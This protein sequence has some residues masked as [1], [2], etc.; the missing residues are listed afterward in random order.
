VRIS[1]IFAFYFPFFCLQGAPLDTA[2]KEIVEAGA[3]L[4]GRGLCPACSGN[5]SRRLDSERIVI[6]VSGKHKG[7]LT[8][9]DTLL[10][11]MQGIS[12]DREK[13]PSAETL[14]HIAIYEGLE[15]VG[16]IM[17]THSL[18]GVVLAQ[19]LKPENFLI[20]EGYELHKVFPGIATHESRLIIPIFENSQDII[21]MSKEVLSY[22]KDHPDTYG[23]LIR[24]HG[25]YTWGKDMN[26]TKTRIEAFE[27]IFEAE[28]KIRT[29]R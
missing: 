18:N 17:H 11:N 4:N 23:F 13:Q 7:S 6:T 27:Y 21:T 3:F 28:L 12:Q 9:E 26:E 29:L 5:L 16:A 1:L 24:G 14:I 22:L 15:K 2:A 19:C 25:F 10:V 20:T 8:I